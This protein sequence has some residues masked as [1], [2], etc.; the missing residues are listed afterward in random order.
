[1]MNPRE[2]VM[3]ALKHQVPDMIPSYV[4]NVLDW[5]RHAL[6]FRVATLGELMEHLGNTILSFSPA[7]VYTDPPALPIHPQTGSPL[8]GMP[9]IWGIPE[10]MI[11]TYTDSMPRPLANAET[12]A[13]IDAYDWPSGSKDAWDFAEMRGR[14]LADN[15][16]A[17]MSPSWT[18]VFSQLCELFGMEEAMVKLHT[19]LPVIEA[20]LD[21]LD[22]FYT[23][24][25]RHMLDTCGDQL[26]I[27]GIGDDFAYN[28]GLLIQPEMWR[29][30]FKPLYA[31]WMG[32]A[33]AIGLVTLMHSCGLIIDVLPDLIDSGLN[34]W[35]T[36]QTHLPGQEASRIKTEFG[37]DLAFV[38]A[39]DTTNVLGFA[40]PDKV[41]VHVREQIRNLG[42]GGGYICAPDHTIMEEVSSENVGAMYETVAAFRSPGYTLL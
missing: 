2:R 7:Y 1:M 9:L 18:P 24:F 5:E 41:R 28:R 35:Q 17:R 34:A 21:H 30:L 16:H 13:D 26:E 15:T 29:K 36:V 23:D 27:F 11:L 6:Y 39:V 10:D 32:M 14:L 37:K 33:K 4:R 38:G 19:N 40:N 12:I 3:T 42:E 8:V 20:A 25:F 31:K 22:A